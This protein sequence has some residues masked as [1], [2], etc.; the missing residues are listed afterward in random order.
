MS[1]AAACTTDAELGIGDNR[2]MPLSDGDS[3]QLIRGP[4]G[5]VMLLLAVRAIGLN[6]AAVRL[7]Y[8]GALLPADTAIADGCW[9]LDLD[10]ADASAY[11]RA[12]IWGALDARYWSAPEPLFDRAAR[13]DVQLTD[14]CGC[15]AIDAKTVHIAPGVR[16]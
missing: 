10:P 11:E 1:C 15:T 7:C 13:F 4:Q 2:Y 9:T 5:G 3:T 8:H 6:P 16:F 12:G 14:S